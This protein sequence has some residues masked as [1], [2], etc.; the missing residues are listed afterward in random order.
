MNLRQQ[1]IAL[2]GDITKRGRKLEADRMRLGK[3]LIRIRQQFIDTQKSGTSLRRG[4]TGSAFCKW[5]T[6]SGM[7]LGTA[8]SYIGLAESGKWPTKYQAFRK[9][10]VFWSQF[11]N[12]MKTATP[13]RKIRLLRGAVAYLITTYEIE[14]V[15]VSIV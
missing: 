2:Y 10:I 14:G 7:N 9:R 12:L 11:A 6:D 1:A 15:K 3:M 4:R 8:Y 5:I 13:A